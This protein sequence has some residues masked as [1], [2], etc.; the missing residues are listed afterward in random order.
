MVLCFVFN[1]SQGYETIKEIYSVDSNNT[2]VKAFL[3]SGAYSELSSDIKSKLKKKDILYVTCERIN[4]ISFY[5]LLTPQGGSDT[6]W[7]GVCTSPTHTSFA[8]NIHTLGPNG[9]FTKYKCKNLE[10]TVLLSFDLNSDYKI[11]N[12]SYSET[13]LDLSDAGPLTRHI[14][15][16]CETMGWNACMNC[17][18]TAC[19]NNWWCALGCSVAFQYSSVAC[20]AAFGFSCAIHDFD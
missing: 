15:E 9:D 14:F 2:V 3:E 17:A 20:A 19:S 10:G 4:M 7:L 11:G 18:T 13:A 1:S 16:D 6:T 8:T 5:F 12:I